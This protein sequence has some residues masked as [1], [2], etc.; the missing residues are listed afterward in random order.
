MA[1]IKREG[2]KIPPDPPDP[3]VTDVDKILTKETELTS[4]GP[5][6]LIQNEIA[7]LALK[8]WDKPIKISHLPDWIRRTTIWL[9]RT[10]T[11]S[12]TYGPYE[13]FLTAMATDNIASQFGT[14]SLKDFFNSEV[15]SSSINDEE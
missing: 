13:F 15:K 7:Y 5:Y 2:A 4:G 12:K 1:P 14:K 3:R 10:F 8:A 9:L 6:I 11:S